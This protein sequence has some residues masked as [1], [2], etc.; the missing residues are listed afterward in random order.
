[1]SRK[2][3]DVRP[4]ERELW[5][6]FVE[7]ATR[8]HPERP[9]IASPEMP[10]NL[11]K[12]AVP[13]VE[14]PRIPQFKLGQKARQKP[15]RHDLLPS[16]PSRLAAAPLQ[17][18]HKAF[19]K[20]KRGKLVP[21]ARVDLHGMTLAQAHPVLVDF[22]QSSYA[23]Q[24]RLVLVITGKGKQAVDDG[25]MPSRRGVLKHQLPQWLSMAPISPMI[26]Q[27]SESHGRHGGS[28]AFYVYLR[29]QR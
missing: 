8:Q 25:P 10:A 3:R 24:L 2:P 15:P 19:G 13:D 11:K 18:D 21:E 16:L 4:G 5:N 20:M 1:M 12:V 14:N 28:G 7:K 9:T 27:V 22:I 6:R 26:L 23:R 29:R 17:M